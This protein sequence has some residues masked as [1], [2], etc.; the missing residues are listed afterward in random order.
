MKKIFFTFV[1]ACML[2][3]INLFAQSCCT[4]NAGSPK[5][6]CKDSVQIGGSPAVTNNCGRGC[7]SISY[8]WLPTTG[9]SNPHVANPWVHPTSTTVYT[10]TVVIINT[11]FHDTCCK[12]T[13]TVTVTYLPRC[14]ANAGTPQTICCP[15]GTVTIGGNPAAVD[16]CSGCDSTLYSWLPTTGLSNSHAANPHAS[17]STTT[18]YTLHIYA[19]NRSNH[20]TCCTASSTVKVTVNGSCCRT[21]NINSVT[22]N[23]SIKIYPN[24]TS[25]LFTIEI[26][27]ALI[28]G[29]VSIYDINGKMIWKKGGLKG[30]ENLPVDLKDIQKGI[31]FIEIN[32]SDKKVYS[33]KLFV[34]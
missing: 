31:Y 19:Y 10:L 8:S 21:T 7:T 17:P 34:Q 13:S 14:S 29:E 5:S 3:S 2:Q 27:Q 6:Y 20:D 30:N 11:I 23:N 25:Q 1:F 15:G 26:G 24:P 9:L 33:D 22:A 4:A 12:S 28:N 16:S 32:D 18:T